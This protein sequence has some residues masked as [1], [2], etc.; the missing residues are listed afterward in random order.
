MILLSGAPAPARASW[1]GVAENDEIRVFASRA[2]LVRQGSLVKMWALLDYDTPQK[3]AQGTFRSAQTQDEYD[4]AERRTRLLVVTR[5]E[6]RMGSGK[7][8]HTDR[9][10]GDWEDLPADGLLPILWRFACRGL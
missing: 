4:C 3:A 5:H 1:V 7:V 6:G 2:T 10:V 8:L 9:T